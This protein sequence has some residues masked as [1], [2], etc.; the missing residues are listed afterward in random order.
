MI[1]ASDADNCGCHEVENG[2]MR[3]S[4]MSPSSLRVWS[5]ED[6]KRVL[7][8][9]KMSVVTKTDKKVKERGRT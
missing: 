5:A 1:H 3:R 8:I 6:T 9:N 2:E 7:E 4:D